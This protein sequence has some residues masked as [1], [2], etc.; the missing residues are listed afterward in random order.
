MKVYGSRLLRRLAAGFLATASLVAT[1]NAE[2]AADRKPEQLPAGRTVVRI[3]SLPG[4]VQ[5][6][7]P[8]DYSQLLLTA[9][10]DTGERIDV[11]RLAQP[12]AAAAIASVSPTGM[13]RP[14]AAG[15][16]ELKFQVGGQ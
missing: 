11:T 6:K 15:A 16:G 10:L 13:V 8:Y 14:L 4:A 1:T 3:E 12:A 7:H 5:L 2:D 9:E